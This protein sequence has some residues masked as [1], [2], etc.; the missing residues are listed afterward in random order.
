MSTYS[1]SAE[2]YFTVNHGTGGTLRRTTTM[3]FPV[4]GFQVWDIFPLD[5]GLD[6]TRRVL[7]GSEQ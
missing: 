7:Y 3:I 4:T 6:L 2:L 1:T 5:W